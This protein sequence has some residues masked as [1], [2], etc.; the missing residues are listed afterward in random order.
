MKLNVSTLK[1]CNLRICKIQNCKKSQKGFSLLEVLIAMLILSSG[2]VLL[3]TSWGSSYS[4]LKKTQ[5]QF[6]MAAL[7]ERKMME[8]DIEYRGKPLDSIDEEQSDDFGDEYPQYAW[9]MESKKLEIPDLSPLFT[10]VSGGASGE[11]LDIVKKLSD[12]LSK[13]VKEVKVSVIYRTKPKDVEYSVTTYF[14]DYDQPL[15]GVGGIPGLG[16]AGGA[17]TGATGGGTQ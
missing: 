2:V 17:G 1:I 16:G 10:S 15:P 11:L 12:Q 5:V 13:S 8:I 9:R 6:E 14:V 7:L 3:V 4:K